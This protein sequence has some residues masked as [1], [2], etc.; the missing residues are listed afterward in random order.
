MEEQWLL[1]NYQELI[2]SILDGNRTI[3]EPISIANRRRDT[4][5]S[6][7]FL[8]HLLSYQNIHKDNILEVL[9]GIYGKF[10][11]RIDGLKENNIVQVM[12]DRINSE[13]YDPNYI[14]LIENPFPN[15]FFH[16]NNQNSHYYDQSCKICSEVEQLTKIE[17]NI[18]LQLQENESHPLE[19][20]FRSSI[21]SCSE[22]IHYLE[23]NCQKIQSIIHTLRNVDMTQF[24]DLSIKHK[25]IYLKLSGKEDE[26]DSIPENIHHI[27]SNYIHI[28]NLLLKQMIQYYHYLEHQLNDLKEKCQTMETMKRNV[29]SIA[30]LKEEE[31]SEEDE[32]E[33]EQAEQSEQ[34]DEQEEEEGDLT[35]VDG[36]VKKERG[37]LFHNL[38]SFF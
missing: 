14:F 32:D 27:F 4:T 2:K 35:V 36:E 38:T 5:S 8:N 7:S 33:E 26:E 9:A 20:H 25:S 30:Y 3:Q 11:N 12:M 22:S 29:T 24:M 28:H 10:L 15:N 18:P 6:V 37:D 34:S 17:N 16:A 1:I 13:W 19:K 31:Q 21:D 23:E